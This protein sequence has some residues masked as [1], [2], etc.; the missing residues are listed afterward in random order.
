MIDEEVYTM[1]KVNIPQ[2]LSMIKDHWNPRIAGELNG[3]YVKLVKFEGAFDWHH[4]ENE[5]EMFLTV[6]GSFR[7]ETRDESFE[8]DAGEFIIVPRGVEH[9]PV[10]D[11]PCS[12]LL[13]EPATTL[14]TG[15]VRTDKTREK[16]DRI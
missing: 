4:H 1:E 2:K 5:D 10:A 13:F 14:N 7:L 12:V 3:Q 15:S 16:L 6:S 11:E 8:V 9:R